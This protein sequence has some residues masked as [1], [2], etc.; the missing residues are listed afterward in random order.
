MVSKFLNKHHTHA[1]ARWPTV[2]CLGAAPLSRGA[3]M[4]DGL[5]WLNALMATHPQYADFYCPLTNVIMFDPVIAEDGL[6]YER[7]AIERHLKT[8]DT[9]PCVRMSTGGGFVPIGKQLKVNQE[10]KA[11]LERI[12][13]DHNHEDVLLRDR[14]LSDLPH[15]GASANDGDDQ[16]SCSV[17]DVDDDPELSLSPELSMSLPSLAAPPEQPLSGPIGI[18]VDLHYLQTSFAIPGDASIVHFERALAARCGGGPICAR[19]ACDDASHVSGG[20]AEVTAASPAAGADTSQSA[21]RRQLHAQMRKQ[22]YELLLAPPRP[23]TGAHGATDIDMASCILDVARGCSTA[24]AEAA[25]CVTAS[26]RAAILVLVAGDA[27]FTSI[28]RRVLL[29]RCPEPP[30]LPLPL[31]LPP[32]PPPALPAATAAQEASAALAAAA[33]AAAA[34]APS[35]AANTAEGA[36]VSAG[37]AGVTKPAGKDEGEGEDEGME[38]EVAVEFDEPAPASTSALVLAPASPPS[39]ADA[40]SSTTFGAAAGLRACLLVSEG[41]IPPSIARFTSAAAAPPSSRRLGEGS[42]SAAFLDVRHA[43]LLALLPT[44][45]PGIDLRKAKAARD[46]R[47]RRERETA[48]RAAQKEEQIEAKRLQ[49]EAEKNAKKLAKK[50][51]EEAKKDAKARELE[52][53][54]RKRDEERGEKK[55]ILKKEAPATDAQKEKWRVAAAK[56]GFAVGQ[57]VEAP[58]LRGGAEGQFDGSWYEG[59]VVAM[60]ARGVRVRFERSQEWPESTFPDDEIDEL[61]ASVFFEVMRPAPPPRPAAFEP[62]LCHACPLEMHAEGGWWEVELLGASHGPLADPIA[63]E[64]TDLDE[65]SER[66]PLEAEGPITYVVRLL[67]APSEGIGVYDATLERLRPGWLW[68]NCKWSGPW[69]TGT[70]N[71]A[72]PFVLSGA[73]E[74]GSSIVELEDGVAVSGGAASSRAKGSKKAA[75]PRVRAKGGAARKSGKSDE[76]SAMTKLVAL[77]PIGTRIE[78]MQM[79][80]GLE[81]AWFEGEVLGHAPPDLCTIRYD[82]LHEGDDSEDEALGGHGEGAAGAKTEAALVGV[83][84]EAAAQSTPSV[85]T[86]TASG[87]MEAGTTEAEAMEVQ[88]VSPVDADGEDVGREAAG[89]NNGHG[90]GGNGSGGHGNSSGAKGAHHGAKGYT[91]ANGVYW[92]PL[93]ESHESIERI[94]PCPAA[95]HGASHDRWIRSLEP[96]AALDLKYDGGWWAVELIQVLAPGAPL[97]DPPDGVHRESDPAYWASLPLASLQRDPR[98]PAPPA[99]PTLSTSSSAPSMHLIVRAVDFDVEH[100][101]P[102]LALRPGHVYDAAIGTWSTRP[103]PQVH[104]VPGRRGSKGSKGSKGQGGEAAS[105]KA[106]GSKA[107]AAVAAPAAPRATSSD[108][109]R[110][111]K[112]PPGWREQLHHANTKTYPTFHGPNG[113]KVRSIAEAIRMHDEASGDGARIGGMPG[114]E[115]SQSPTQFALG[116]KRKGVDGSSWEV[117]LAGGFQIWV[118]S[119]G[120]GTSSR[121]RGSGSKMV[122]SADPPEADGREGFPQEGSIEGPAADAAVSEQ[123]AAHAVVNEAGTSIDAMADE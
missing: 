71:S 6:T 109:S 75:G 21:G 62:M 93:Y 86:E 9:S 121:R 111:E 12:V 84:A 91:D 55:K 120:A 95:L 26:M 92:P 25:P 11:A 45:V 122:K 49:K 42:G 59:V 114:G 61:E 27:D 34:A 82:E 113:E 117:D 56:K 81:G 94:R 52:E 51:E 103:P 10:R 17:E 3:K 79:D 32:Q 100:V 35:G 58:L 88:L 14:M 8:H 87:A 112:L 77:Y 110:I 31:L 24:A 118:P 73:S 18:V 20:S 43:D 108:G 47:R 66:A 40:S 101:C 2:A 38:V 53:R 4:P 90:S 78:V 7:S 44:L 60:E 67:T 23:L 102:P 80:S 41:G 1:S 99:A 63:Q 74:V 97:P 28:L 96:G 19:F 116:T 83:D 57:R 5:G 115:P 36:S 72:G 105:S 68:R 50:E 69:G 123:R 33:A 104:I 64:V 37:D 89:C 13:R 22:G 48:T 76:E 29:P 85:K 119:A 65:S 106:K 30:P 46:L 54:K 98:L 107:A 39:A 16:Q 15:D 70:G